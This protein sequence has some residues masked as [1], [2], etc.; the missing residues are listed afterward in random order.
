VPILFAHWV[1]LAFG[2]GD[3][4]RKN[5]LVILVA[6]ILGVI[7]STLSLFS[8]FLIKSVSQKLSFVFWPDSGSLYVLYVLF[9]YIALTVYTG[10]LLLKYYKRSSG[11]LRNQI[12]YVSVGCLIALLGGFF[13]FFLWYDI[14]IMP[15]GN[16]II[17]IYPVLISYAIIKYRLMNIKLV[18]TRSILYA[19]LVGSV[20][21]FFAFSIFYIGPMVVGNTRSSHVI[22]TI[23]SSIFNCCIFR[24]S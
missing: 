18:V 2:S 23:I 6:Y 12:K 5:R 7:F 15:Y 11:L 9:I 17:P 3:R 1:Y 16:F 21:S 13:N 4:T 24:S 22:S 20:A 19:I 10:L 8:N 14:P